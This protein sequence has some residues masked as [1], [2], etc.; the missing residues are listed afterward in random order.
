MNINTFGMLLAGRACSGGKD[1]R[2]VFAGCFLLDFIKR[3]NSSVI[4][5]YFAFSYV[6]GI[7]CKG[8]NPRTLQL[9]CG[10]IP[11]SA[12]YQTKGHRLT[13][14]FWF[15]DILLPDAGVAFLQ[16][17]KQELGGFIV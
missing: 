6:G 5:R 3:L 15:N 11:K 1:D 4:L 16:L 8:D 7:T 14:V 10:I 9:A 13:D 2:R 17:C 12:A